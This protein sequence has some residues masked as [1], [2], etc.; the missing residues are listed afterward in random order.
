MYYKPI[1]FLLFLENINVVRR[2]KEVKKYIYKLVKMD[3][4]L[5]LVTIEVEIID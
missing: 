3:K 1:D 4:S 2:K 5:I